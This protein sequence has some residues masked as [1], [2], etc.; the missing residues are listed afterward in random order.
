MRPSKTPVPRKRRAGRNNLGVNQARLSDSKLSGISL[1]LEYLFEYGVNFK[2]RIITLSDSIEPPMF[3]FVDAALSEMESMNG[4]AVTIRIK[5]EGGDVYDAMAIVGRMKRSK[6][7]IIT[8]GYGAIMSAA[9]LILAAGNKRRISQYAVFMHHEA[10]YHLATARHSEQQATVK[11]METEEKLW[12]KW[13]ATFSGKT[14]KFWYEKGKHMDAYF[15]PEQLLKFGV[16]E[17][18]F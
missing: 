9:T 5:S 16:V 17:E 1:H 2:D 8:E 14:E 3:D 7:K 11:Q 12:S 13:M 6:C 18:V 15:T 4:K 10:W